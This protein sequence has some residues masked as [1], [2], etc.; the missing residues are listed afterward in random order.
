MLYRKLEEKNVPT[1]SLHVS[2][3]DAQIYL[4]NVPQFSA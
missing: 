2:I 4:V 1:V 3:P